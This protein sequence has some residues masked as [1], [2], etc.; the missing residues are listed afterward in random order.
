[1]FLIESM[2]DEKEDCMSD[3]SAYELLLGACR[4]GDLKVL[5]RL[6]NQ[7]TNI[8]YIEG[9]VC[10]ASRYGWLEVI[11]CLVSGVGDNVSVNCNEAIYHAA[12][13]G[14]LETVK[15][16][17]S[18]GDELKDFGKFALREAA[19]YG[20]LNVV[21][22]LV[23]QGADPRVDDDALQ[24]AAENDHLDVV[25]YLMENGADATA[26]CCG[27]VR[28]ACKNENIDMIECLV[29]QRSNMMKLQ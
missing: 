6:V 8:M 15:Y 27:A 24:M 21:K 9:A 23:S 2:E 25:E 22:Y 3:K 4:G 1:V 17:V 26:G 12:G 13:N 29:R 16:L 10:F 19:K 14:H 18:Q 11:K 28:A 7:C 20:H 5:E